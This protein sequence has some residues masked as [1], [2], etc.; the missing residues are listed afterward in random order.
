MKQLVERSMD[1]AVTFGGEPRVDKPEFILGRL[2]HKKKPIN[3]PDFSE[4]APWRGF[5]DRTWM[6]VDS[7]SILDGSNE[8]CT[9]RFDPQRQVHPSDKPRDIDR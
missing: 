5:T 4:D 2:R 8:D 9:K 1:E 3:F 6:S 7:A